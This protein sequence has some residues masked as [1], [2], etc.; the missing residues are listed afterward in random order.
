[1]WS[2]ES[3]YGFLL[4]QCPLREFEGW[5]LFYRFQSFC[6]SALYPNPQP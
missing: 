2:R 3:F 5:L 4:A 1:M 6:T